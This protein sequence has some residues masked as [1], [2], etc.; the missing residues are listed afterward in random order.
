MNR[1]LPDDPPPSLVAYELY[2][3]AVLFV[4]ALPPAPRVPGLTKAEQEVLALLL[5]GYDT[6]SIAELRG[7]APSTVTNQVASIFKKVGV[8]SRAELAAKVLG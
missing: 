3:G 7:T 8:G 1:P 6:R 5:D 4:H 2:D